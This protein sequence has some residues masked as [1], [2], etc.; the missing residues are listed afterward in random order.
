MRRRFA[1]TLLVL[2]ALGGALM[3]A[4]D[5]PENDKVVALPPFMVEETGKGPPWRYV[6]LPGFEV[7]SRCSDLSTRTVTQAYVQLHRL[8]AVVLP[9][10][11]QIQLTEP[12][13]V[14]LYD[15]ELHPAASQ[16]VVAQMLRIAGANRPPLDDL[17]D[18]GPRG[19]RPSSAP[20]RVSFL[21]NLR[22]TDKDA[23]TVFT[24]VR[25]DGLNTDSLYLTTD[26]VTYMLRN[27][28]PVLPLWFVAGFL[29]AYREMTFRPGEIT[30]KP[31]QWISEAET[32]VVKKT[33]AAARQPVALGEFFRGDLLRTEPTDLNGAQHWAAQ[34][35]LFVRW[36][37]DD[38]NPA[39]RQALWKF[40][41][42]VSEA[43]SSE[44][45]FAECFGFDYA[46]AQKQLAEFL[47]VAVRRTVNYRLDR[48]L[49][50]PAVALRDAT[51]G[52]IARIKGDWERLEIGYVKEHFPALAPKYLEQARRTLMRAYERDERDPRLLAV[53]GLCARDA[54]DDGPAREYLEAAAQS[55]TM[56]ARAW[57]EL[58]RL[59]YAEALAQPGGTG[60]QLTSTQAA[61]VLTPLFTAR[62]QR[63]P[64]PEVYELIASVWAHCDFPPTRAHLAALDEGV[65]LFPRN[66]GLVFQAA[67]LYVARGWVSDAR[68]YVELGLQVASDDATRARFTDLQSRLP[69]TPP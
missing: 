61:N 46:E 38:R 48:S 54:G 28:V 56:R 57:L 14:I 53:L 33:P 27:R 10:E 60:G 19:V 15:E 67:S 22:L 7:L 52:E 58:A 45:R 20:R 42:R 17:P 55:G 63:P 68:I 40:V 66:A 25:Q 31:L 29:S 3:R 39:R 36:G 8:L 62:Q 16:E 23:I 44:Q 4:A 21:P 49:K 47:P 37:L 41:A 9:E 26:Y 34:A 43:S 13:V 11:L 50:P 59:R 30:L 51:F 24:I 6:E 64:L 18:I 69:P 65:A 12:R 1:S 5:A 32:E 35:A 2:T